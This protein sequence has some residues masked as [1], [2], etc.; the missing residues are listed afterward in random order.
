MTTG[1]VV[2]VCLGPGG[3]PKHPVDNAEVTPAGLVGDGHRYVEHGGDN[4]AVCLLA[5]ESYASLARDRASVTPPGVFG[6]NLLT[7]GLDYGLLRPG[8]CL[9]VGPE[10]RLRIHDVREPCGTLKSVDPRF[11]D[12]MLGR[13]GFVCSVMTP[14]IVA[15]GMSI[16]ILPTP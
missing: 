12:L 2:A 10:L 7:E 14:G 1:V 4:R 16:T 8:D 3:I 15:P 6:E 11:P 5:I 13:S 9:A